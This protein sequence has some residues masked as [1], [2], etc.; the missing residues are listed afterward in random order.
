MDVQTFLTEIIPI[1]DPD[2]RSILEAECRIE[3]FRQ[4]ESIDELYTVDAFIRFLISGV[5]RGYIIDEHGKESTTDF[6]TRPGYCIAGL[7]LVHGGSSDIGF[8]VEKDS[9]VF[10]I[11]VETVLRLKGHPEM[12]DL[13]IFYYAKSVEIH[14]TTEKM[15]YLK[16]A[17]ERYEWFLKRYPGLIEY[18][19]HS[20]IA[21]LLNMTPVTLSRIRHKKQQHLYSW[22]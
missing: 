8:G 10:S 16:T 15:L 19:P 14:W 18:V 20:H 3:T 7:R 2:L 9:E 11:P 1:K 12:V 13:L 17:E 4:G 21:S 22:P 6:A 5:I